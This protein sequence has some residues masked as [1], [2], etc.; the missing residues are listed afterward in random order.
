M[1]AKTLREHMIEMQTE[2]KG[3]KK[4]VWGLAAF[5]LAERGVYYAPEEIKYLMTLILGLW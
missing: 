4:I 5:I 1:K 3:V 2:F